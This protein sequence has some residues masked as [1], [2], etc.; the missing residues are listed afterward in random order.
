MTALRALEKTENA[1]IK[2]AADAESPFAEVLEE[3]IKTVDDGDGTRAIS[4]DEGQALALARALQLWEECVKKNL[5]DEMSRLDTADLITKLKKTRAGRRT[6]GWNATP[7]YDMIKE[8]R[9]WLHHLVGESFG[10]RKDP[11]V[12]SGWCNALKYVLGMVMQGEPLCPDKER[13]KLTDKQ[14]EEWVRLELMLNYCGSAPPPP[15]CLP[16]AHQVNLR[17]RAGAFQAAADRCRRT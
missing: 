16:Q 8:L 14:E 7:K 1:I 12:A 2:R 9:S 3:A 13:Y 5:P 17:R 10:T 4:A 11:Q 6:T 15:R